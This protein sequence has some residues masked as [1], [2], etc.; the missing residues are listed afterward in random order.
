MADLSFILRQ[1]ENTFQNFEIQQELIVIFQE[2]WTEPG[3]LSTW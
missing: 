2:L 3:S 1:N